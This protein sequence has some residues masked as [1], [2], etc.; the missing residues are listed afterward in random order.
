MPSATLPRQNLEAEQSVIGACLLS[1]NAIEACLRVVSPVDFYSARLGLIYGAIVQLYSTGNPVDVI[2]VAAE[3]NDPEVVSVAQLNSLTVD[4][5]AISSAVGYAQIIVEHSDA[6]R[7]QDQARQAIDAIQ[8]GGDPYEAGESLVSQVQGLERAGTIPAGFTTFDEILDS[9]ELLAPEII[10]GVCYADSRIVVVA[11]EKGG[12]S[13]LLRQIAFC[14]S[15][16]IHPFRTDEVIDPV[17]VLVLDLEN[18]VR[19]LQTTGHLLRHRLKKLVDYDPSRL[20]IFRR[21]GGI[22]ITARHDRGELEA[23]LEHFRPQ[24]IVGGPVYKMTPASKWDNE[25]KKADAV[26]NELDRLR[27]RFGCALMIEHHAPIGNGGSRE[28]RGMG[29][30]LWQAWPDVSI[31]LKSENNY[32]QF[33]VERPHP[34]RGSF[35]WPTSFTRGRTWPWEANYRTTEEV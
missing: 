7:I 8:A 12:K 3:V 32:R 17:R 35:D 5:P 34:E 23:V 19:E 31:S 18:P 28:L 10:P 21:P 24:L 9:E 20:M 13:V 30:T 29:G 27:I 11:T 4:V 16:G 14:A 15:Q 33:N 6:R 1:R 2:T 22:D 26:Q 25:Q